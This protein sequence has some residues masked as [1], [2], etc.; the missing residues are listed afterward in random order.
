[1]R[2]KPDA[3][4]AYGG[5]AEAWVNHPSA[6]HPM[7]TCARRGRAGLLLGAAHEVDFGL[8]K[9]SCEPRTRGY[10]R[11]QQLRRARQV[12]GMTLEQ[13]AR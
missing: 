6:G 8:A 5:L 13:W 1:M 3:E 2:F 7:L 11:L 10:R 9:L 12:K 4:G